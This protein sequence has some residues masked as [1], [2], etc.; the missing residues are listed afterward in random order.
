MCP[1][2][3][4]IRFGDLKALK[5]RHYEKIPDASEYA[6]APPRQRGFFAFPYAFFDRCYIM[7]H[8]ACEAHSQMVYLRDGNGRKL[9]DADKDVLSETE[10]EFCPETGLRRP[11]VIRTMTDNELLKKLGLPKQPIKREYRPSWVCVMRN[12]KPPPCLNEDGML[13]RQF[14]YLTGSNGERVPVRG[15]F[16]RKWYPSDFDAA[17]DFDYCTPDNIL[18]ESVYLLGLGNQSGFLLNWDGDGVKLTLDY[19]RKRGI[20][21]E[22]LFAW[23][24]YPPGEDVWLTL[25]KKPHIFDY[26]G[27]IWHHLRHFVPPRAVLAAYG[28]TWV[29]TTMRDFERAL[30]RAEPQA[31]GKQRALRGNAKASLFGGP[32]C[33]NAEI[34]IE[35]M[36]ETFFDED[37]IKKIT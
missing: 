36:Y 32:N 30:R 23:P 33:P 18:D 14:D 8:P 12:P 34:T 5:Q 13:D 19:L 15:F 24:V 31:Y 28:T 26:D 4:F 22:R 1:K 16:R 7:C 11:K 6:N 35:G 20:G 10:T 21:V 25:F 9:T 37:D 3:K 2:M 29:Y 27:C 17:G